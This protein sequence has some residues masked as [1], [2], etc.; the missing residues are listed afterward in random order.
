MLKIRTL[1]NSDVF[2]SASACFSVIRNEFM[3][4]EGEREAGVLF[5]FYNIVALS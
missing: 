4:V 5:I 3:G 2:S 1:Q